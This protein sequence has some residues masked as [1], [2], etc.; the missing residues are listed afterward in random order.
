[1]KANAKI[2]ASQATLDIQQQFQNAI[3]SS[4]ARRILK[5][6]GYHGRVPRK[7][8]VYRFANR[9]KSIALENM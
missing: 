1:M 3:S 5:N 7:K 9:Q 6:A 2:N 4:T 8:I